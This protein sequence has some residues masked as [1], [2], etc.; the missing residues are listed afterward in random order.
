MSNRIT[1]DA[2]RILH[3][4]DESSDDPNFSHQSS[5]SPS[6]SPHSKHESHPSHKQQAE[7]TD[8]WVEE[9]FNLGC[10][11]EQCKGID[12]RQ[13]KETD[14]LSDDDEYCE[15]VRAPSAEPDTL[16][17]E[18]EGLNLHSKEVNLNRTTESKSKGVKVDQ[19]KQREDSDSFTSCSLS[20]S[21]CSK[22]APLQQC[23]VEGA[24]NKDHDIWVRR[25]NFGKG[26]NSDVFWC[27]M[28]ESENWGVFF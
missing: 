2:D 5:C 7:D 4:N 13:V 24:T 15:S 18:V 8:R 3:N 16:E 19:R 11:E 12:D 26:C 28:T 14:I 25:D 22:V 10:Y 1:I 20:L 17:A 6:T 21:H 27:R 23:A 9:Q